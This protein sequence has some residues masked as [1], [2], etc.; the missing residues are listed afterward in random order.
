MEEG[1][2]EMAY[3]HN[4]GPSVASN[5]YLVREGFEN[6]HLL[7][8]IAFSSLEHR[9]AFKYAVNVISYLIIYLLFMPLLWGKVG[10]E[11]PAGDSVNGPKHAWDAPV[12]SI[13]L[14]VR[15]LCTVTYDLHALP[16]FCLQTYVLEAVL[17]G[18]WE[19]LAIGVL[20][21]SP[22]DICSPFFSKAEDRLPLAKQASDLLPS[23]CFISAASN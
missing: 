19:D 23:T 12:I 10:K 4:Q 9:I 16:C 22:A 3:R 18:F 14:Q 2:R 21:G 6:R 13:W 11:L 5:Y 17:K 8:N 15:W 20:E 1:L 7:F